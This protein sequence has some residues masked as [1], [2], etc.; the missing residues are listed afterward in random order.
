MDFMECRFSTPVSP[1]YNRHGWLGFK[2]HLSVFDL[3]AI[4]FISIAVLVITVMV[5]WALKTNY[6]SL[7]WVQKL[8]LVLL[9]FSH[10]GWLGIK[11][12]LS[13]FDLGAKI[14]ISITVL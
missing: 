12:Q 2:N 1:W 9:Y 5:D 11:N 13:V 3:G 8:L 7:I 6:L 14:V 10:H 4:F